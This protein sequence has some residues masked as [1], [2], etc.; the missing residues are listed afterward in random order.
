M[1]RVAVIPRPVAVTAGAG[2]LPVTADTALLADRDSGAAARLL[3]AWLPAVGG[4]PR[5]A[6]TL[7]ST[8]PP[9]AITL[10]TDTTRTD[11]HD[12]GYALTVTPRGTPRSPAPRRAACCGAR[13][14]CASF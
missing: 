9:G 1:S 12:E 6:H 14:R 11:L 10:T 13:K 8:A 7:G 2:A 4:Q 3:A 5:G